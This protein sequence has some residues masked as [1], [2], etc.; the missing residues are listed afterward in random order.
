MTFSLIDEF[1]EALGAMP[2][3]DVHTH[4]DASHL[5]ARG[6]D[7]ILLYH[8]STS[9]L[10]AAGCPSGARV[11][12]DRSPQEARRRVQQALPFLPKVQN[13]FMAWG[14]RVI[15]ADLYGWKKAITPD[16]W[17]TL[18][19]MIAEHSRDAKWPR[20]ILK[21]AGI[22]R[23]A[24][25][26]WRGR[27]G[28]ADD[29]F[30]YGLEWA[31]FTRTQWGQPDIPVYELERTWNQAA[32]AP[33]IPMT[34]NRKQ[35][36][37]LAKTIRTVADVHAALQH[38]C[39]LIPFGIVLSTAFHIS[40]EIDYSYPSD[41]T[42]ADALKRREAA[43]DR[44]RDVYAS[45]I[46]HHFLEEIEKRGSQIVLQFSLGA[47]A[48]PYESCSRL[49]QRTVGQLGDIIARYPRLR[50]QC[51][52]SSRHAN[53]SL[54]TLVRELPNLSLAGYWLHNFFPGPIRQTIEERLDML[55]ANRQ[56]GFFSDAYCIEWAYAKRVL[57][58][59][60]AAEVLAH[61]VDIGQYTKKDAIAI[62][63]AVFYDSAVEL[64]GMQSS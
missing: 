31:F 42:M 57:V 10:Y 40:A 27:G 20:S 28:V 59:K 26:L 56:I 49:F 50:F 7:D 5:S 48:L 32:P 55:P 4:I 38:Y 46:L 11:E 36:P 54:C 24:T 13:T 21:R 52:L 14:I 17:E 19:A 9:E 45:Y 63:Q 37:P 62:A 6:L 44:E 8:M 2:W 60:L 23:T 16:N 30:Q 18:D 15:L 51:F 58:T 12:E 64:L 3:M 39:A 33:P 53:Q 41:A 34:F 1:E 25:E 35:A 22:A 29:L 61:K 43:T 47:E